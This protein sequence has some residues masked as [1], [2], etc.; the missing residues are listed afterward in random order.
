MTAVSPFCATYLSSCFSATLRDLR[1]FSNAFSTS[2][3]SKVV[4]FLVTVIFSKSMAGIVGKISN[5]S[6]YS[7]SLPISHFAKSARGEPAKRNFLSARYAF[8]SRFIN[9][10][11]ASAVADVLYFW[12]KMDNGICPGRNPGI[13][14]FLPYSVSI[15]S[16][17]V[18]NS[19]AVIRP[20]TE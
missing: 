17:A 2:D 20:V 8:K 19:S 5:S 4:V 16:A 13:F 3:S 12:R 18:C 6:V 11:I 15:S 9:L 10:S 1:M 14:A 7:A